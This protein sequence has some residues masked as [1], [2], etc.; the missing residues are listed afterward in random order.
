MIANYSLR[1]VSWIVI[2]LVASVL[3]AEARHA[4]SGSVVVMTRNLYVGADILRIVEVESPSDIPLVVAETLETVRRSQPAE[5]MAAIADEI[6]K[7]KPHLVGLQ[8]AFQI[9]TQ[10]PGDFFIGNPHPAEYVEVDYLELLLGA[11]E[12]RGLHYRVAAA[13]ANIDV[14]LPGFAGLGP[15]GEPLFMDVR[16][17]EI[18][19]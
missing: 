19:C 11:L 13:L 5:R 10:F 6:A 7:R 8:E 16:V 14:E 17:V 18:S 4:R 12:D 2:V 15:M 9:K 3:H 1:C